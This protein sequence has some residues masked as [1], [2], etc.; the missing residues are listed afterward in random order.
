[1]E[2]L[3]A[4]HDH[5]RPALS[6]GDGGEPP[7]RVLRALTPLGIDLGEVTTRLLNEG[8]EKF[9]TPYEPL[10]RSLDGTRRLHS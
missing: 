8:I 6:L 9:V 4:Y 3:L 2:T 7:D 10:Q 1:M 5:G